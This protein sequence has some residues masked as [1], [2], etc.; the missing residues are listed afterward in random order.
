ML[1]VESGQCFSLTDFVL[2]TSLIGK[3]S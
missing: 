1:E 3:V 2:N